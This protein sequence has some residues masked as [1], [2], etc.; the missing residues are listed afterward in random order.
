MFRNGF[1]HESYSSLFQKKKKTD[2]LT[3][4]A[5]SLQGIKLHTT[6]YL[7]QVSLNEN[8]SSRTIEKLHNELGDFA[9]LII[10]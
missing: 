5:L 10:L 9:L 3:H 7:G 8:K 6:R 1:L 4:T 2:T